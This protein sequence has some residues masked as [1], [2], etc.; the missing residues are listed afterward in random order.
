MRY[1]SP[2]NPMDARVAPQ[3]CP[4]LPWGKTGLYY[5]NIWRLS[6]CMMALFVRHSG[7]KTPERW[8]YF[9]GEVALKLRASCLFGA[10][11]SSCR[12]CRPTSHAATL[13]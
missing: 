11:Y 5:R 3:R 12:F 8:P 9:S 6:R 10:E 7:P 2:R 13:P 1:H 4:I